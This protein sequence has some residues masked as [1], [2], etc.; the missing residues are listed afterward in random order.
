LIIPR[1]FFLLSYRQRFVLVRRIGQQL[2]EEVHPMMLGV[3]EKRG[4]DPVLARTLARAIEGSSKPRR[5]IARETGLHKDSLLGII[6]GTRPVT[7]SEAVSLLAAAGVPPKGVLSLVLSGKEDLAYQWM[8]TDMGHFWDELIAT[9]PDSL[10]ALGDSIEEI[11]PR[12]AVG[13]AKLVAKLLADH[14]REVVDR[15]LSAR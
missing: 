9:L 10:A 13:T 15:D 5:T 3:V 11:R 12:W 6:R 7:T 14:I 2:N 8:H 4:V 1:L